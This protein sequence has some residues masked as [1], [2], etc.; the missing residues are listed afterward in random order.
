MILLGIL[1]K[2]EIITVFNIYCSININYTMN[3][4]LKSHMCNQFNNPLAVQDQIDTLFHECGEM[5]IVNI[6]C[7][8]GYNME[9]SFVISREA[10]DVGLFRPVS[11]KKYMVETIYEN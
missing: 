9:D 3:N 1:G 6:A 2:I 4:N 11:I 5:C 7:S 10:I 8:D